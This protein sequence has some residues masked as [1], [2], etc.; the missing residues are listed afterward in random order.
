MDPS[1]FALVPATAPVRQNSISH[2]K[3]QAQ[4][5]ADEMNTKGFGK[6]GKSRLARDL[7]AALESRDELDKLKGE[8][9]AKSGS[10]LF[11]KRVEA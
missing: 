11:A 5:L 9:M 6:S 10:S 4:A 2:I 8:G 3:A 7:E 1:D